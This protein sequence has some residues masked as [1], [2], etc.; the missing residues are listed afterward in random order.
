MTI[1]HSTAWVVHYSTLIQ[2]IRSCIHDDTKYFLTAYSDIFCCQIRPCFKG[3]VINTKK[4]YH[5]H[6]LRFLTVKKFGKF[7]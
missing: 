2:Y 4:N 6:L 3:L 7:C 5:T 1:F